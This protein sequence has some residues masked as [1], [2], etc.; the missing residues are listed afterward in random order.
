K[1]QEQFE[2]IVHDV[3]KIKLFGG[4]LNGAH[5]VFDEIT[6]LRNKKH[7]SQKQ[8]TEQEVPSLVLDDTCFSERDFNLSLMEKVKEI[9]VLPNVYV[10]LEEEGKVHWVRAKE[11]EAWD[12]L[13][14]NEEYDSSSS[15]EEDEH[16]NEGSLNGDKYESDKEVDKVSESSCMHEDAPFFD[17]S[18]NKSRASFTPKENSVNE[19]QEKEM[20]ETIE[21]VKQNLYNSIGKNSLNASYCSQRFQTGGSIIDLMDE[22]VKVGQTM[23]YNMEGLGHKTKKSWIKELCM[24]NRVNFLSLQETKME[25]MELVTINKL[26]GNNSYDYAFS[27]S[28]GTWIP[29]LIDL[30]LDGYACTWV[31]KSATKMSRLD[32]FLISK[33]LMASFPHLSAICLDKHLSDHR[34]ILM[35][36][37]NI[38]YGRT[39]FRFFHSWFQLDGFDK[40]VEDISILPIE[41]QEITSM[42]SE[43]VAQKAKVCWAIEGYENTKYF[44]IIINN[45]RLQLAIRGVL[46]NGD[47]IVEPNAVKSEFLNHFPSQFDRPDTHRIYLADEFS[48][49]ISLEQQEDLERNVTIEEIKRAVWDCG[50]NKS[51]GP[52]GFT[53]EFFQRYWKFLEN[54]IFAAV[55]EFLSSAFVSNLQIL[56]G[57]FILNELLS[58]CKYKKFKAI[59]FKVDFEK[60]FD[61]IQWDYLDDVLK[62]FGFGDKWCGWINGC[63]KSA[64]G[65]V[66]VNGSP[67]LEFHF[68]RGMFTGIPLD[69]SLTISHLFYADDE[70]FVGK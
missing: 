36:E 40:L 57:L 2:I 10:I 63:L 27:S 65:S 49:R 22:L 20:K 19:V 15:N 9:T 14:R 44:H 3:N 45:K 42:D 37:M 11:M 6:A 25:R 34:P 46:V 13:L 68:H 23:G 32:R 35:R 43:E 47:W 12:P 51:P 61:S 38:D 30:P 67:T 56:D 70:I 60:A 33:G 16:K 66:L 24:K 54:D 64:K 1:E 62:K 21:E 26:W 18:N 50:T 8:P 7:E 41:L 48:N 5:N 29:T 59:V 4:G 58:W 52:D 17:N 69:N 31:H 39:P 55:M 53:F 28:L